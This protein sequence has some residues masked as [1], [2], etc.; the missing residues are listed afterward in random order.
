MQSSYAGS[1]VILAY[2]SI[3]ADEKIKE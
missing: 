3:L 1:V 2:N